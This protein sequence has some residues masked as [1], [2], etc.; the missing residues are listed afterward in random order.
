MFE[1]YALCM[2][3]GFIIVKRQKIVCDFFIPI[4]SSTGEAI[5][6]QSSYENYQNGE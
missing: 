6:E 1:A 2:R 3:L 4:V 5:P